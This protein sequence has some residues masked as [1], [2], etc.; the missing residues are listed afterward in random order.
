MSKVYKIFLI[1]MIGLGLGAQDYSTGLEPI[2]DK[3]QRSLA[4]A[5]PR[6][7][8]TRAN[9]LPGN[10]RQNQ[11][12]PQAVDLSQ[13][14]PPIRSQGQIGSCSA[15]ST[16]YYGKSLQEN[17]ERH[18]GAESEDHQFSPLY[19]YN[20]ITNGRNQGTAIIDHMNLVIEQGVAPWSS[21]PYPYDL[22]ARPDSRARQSAEPYK[23]ESARSL[24]SYNQNTGNWEVD[25]NEIKTILAQGNVIIGGFD[26]YQEF[27]DYHGGIYRN[28]RGPVISGH[29]M[30]I[31][32]Y[33]DS[34]SSFRIVNSWGE[35]WGEGGFMWMHYDFAKT[36]LNWGCAVMVDIVDSP[37]QQAVP[38]TGLE[39][40]QGG[41]S[42]SITLKW[43]AV[44][45]A[46][47]Y[48]IYRADNSSNQLEEHQR[49][50]TTSFT[51][52]DIPGGVTYLYTVASIVNGQVSGY[53]ELGQGWTVAEASAPGIPT[54][55][56]NYFNGQF[57]LLNWD[58]LVTAEIYRIYR[59][60][61]EGEQY[62]LLGTSKDS[63]Y[64]D[65]SI[66]QLFGE[67]SGSYY[68]I[69]GVNPQGEGQS[70]D[71]QR[72]AF[73]SPRE[74]NDALELLAMATA[75]DDTSVQDGQEFDGEYHRT[76][77]FDYEY[78]M[79]QFRAYQEAERRAF[80]NWRSDQQNAFDEWKNRQRR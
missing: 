70:S 72:V 52:D 51:D 25:I 44:N 53:S 67:V 8:V 14:L 77:Y 78:T 38:P 57:L 2:P 34:K 13:W 73:I 56:E 27:Y 60:D 3:L 19:T 4:Q 47:G 55:I 23:A 32:G 33:D 50:R 64:V 36:A 48:V 46:T 49:V 39:C 16:I 68:L 58:D 63:A 71:A 66:T 31:V 79:A 10:G 54:N 29:A 37:Q 20:Q 69:S 7:L 61:E 65:K 80:Q 42:N 30:C 5:Q 26:I 22:N 75:Q 41:E 76:Q 45:G 21:F 12:M 24:S 43:D 62:N 17:M 18:W 74:H 1:F 15:W 9:S 6:G 35:N 28:P 59:W 11:T 40:S